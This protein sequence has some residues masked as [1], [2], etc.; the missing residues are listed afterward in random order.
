MIAY[1]PYAG[2]WRAATY[3]VNKKALP[4]I[5]KLKSYGHPLSSSDPDLQKLLA[6]PL[7][8]GVR[9]FMYQL[10][11]AFI[12][13]PAYKP[14][15]PMI[16]K[17]LEDEKLKSDD[18][19]ISFWGAFEGAV[20]GWMLGVGWITARRTFHQGLVDI[21]GLEPGDLWILQVEPASLLGEPRVQTYLFD[22]TK[23]P[24]GAVMNCDFPF[25]ELEAVEA[26]DLRL[27][28]E[29]LNSGKPM[30]RTFMDAYY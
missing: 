18:V 14:M 26:T 29:Q 5:K 12:N 4:K 2:N 7:F 6:G 13:V 15:V 16:E 17:L 9:Q 11:G 20:L 1:R 22:V 3:I 8:A 30:T 27:T 23:G 24:P 25:A 21:C 28:P 19:I 10:L